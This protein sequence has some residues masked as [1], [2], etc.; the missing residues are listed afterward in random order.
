VLTPVR[1]SG[2]VR[3]FDFEGDVMKILVTG[4]TGFI[5]AAVARQLSQ[6]HHE[7]LARLGPTPPEHSMSPNVSRKLSPAWWGC[8]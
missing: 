8:G 1:Y 2:L 6:Q 7:I 4:A 3:E 5:G